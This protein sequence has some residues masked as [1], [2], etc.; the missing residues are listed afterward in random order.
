M[1]DL[2]VSDDDDSDGIDPGL[3][4]SAHSE[5]STNKLLKDIKLTKMYLQYHQA[6]LLE[7]ADLNLNYGNRYGLVGR[8]GCGKSVLLTALAQGAFELP[9]GLTKY[10]LDKEAEASDQT[11]LEAVMSADKERE[12]I[13]ARI[14]ELEALQD[15]GSGD[16]EDIADQLAEAYEAAARLDP[17]EAKP[18]AI[19]ILRG[20]GF[21]DS[22]LHKK[23]KD[24]SGGW[25]M[26]IALARALF[27]DPDFLILDEPT[28]HL[29]MESVVWLEEYLKRFNK[30]LVVVSHSQDFLNGVCTHIIRFHDKKLTE[31]S[32]NYDTYLKTRREKETQQMKRYTAEQKDIQQLKDF[33]SKFGHGTKK[34]AAQGKSREKILNRKIMGGLTERVVDD[35]P[36]DFTFGDPGN[37][38]TPLIQFQDVSFGY[39]EDSLLYKNL[40]FGMY[41]TTRMVLVGANGAGKSTLLKLMAR[42]L[43]PVKGSVM[44]NGKLKVS[45]FEQHS[46]EE[47]DPTATPLGILSKDRPEMLPAELRKILGRFGLTGDVQTTPMSCLSGGQKARLV[48]LKIYMEN[49]HLL[50]LDE[51]TNALDME[52]IDALAK[53]LNEFKGAVVLVS[54]DMRLISQVA[55]QIVIVDGGTMTTYKGTIEAF[56]KDLQ[57]KLRSSRTS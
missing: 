27:L 24:Y 52:S 36:V 28:N 20:L 46:T 47:F 25:R 30:L 2:K 22:M 53:A 13:E 42:E 50:L 31:Y 49:P 41:P 15:E 7:E 12:R 19:Q 51:P 57:K 37:L 55:K 34:L 39:S 35:S 5:A 23:T 32:G 18:K 1:E 8:N 17:D 40:D 21:S 45:K 6:N 29:D 54:H 11:A 26:R 16:D 10:H 14:E 9:Q 56:K 38:P 44:V 43:K 33:V 4:A 48:F 3:T